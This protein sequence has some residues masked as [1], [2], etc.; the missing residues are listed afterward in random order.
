MGRI[1][2]VR[3][4]KMPQERKGCTGLYTSC[5]DLLSKYSQNHLIIFNVVAFGIP[6]NWSQYI[7]REGAL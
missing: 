1:F 5:L 4:Y 6:G 3:F 2:E 7:P